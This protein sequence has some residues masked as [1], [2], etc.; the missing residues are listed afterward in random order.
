MGY[1]RNYLPAIA[2]TYDFLV[3]S[4][5]VYIAKFMSRY[6]GIMFCCPSWSYY[7]HLDYSCDLSN[8]CCSLVVP[9][10]FL[11]IN[12]GSKRV[13]LGWFFFMTLYSQFQRTTL[14]IKSILEIR[15]FNS[16][17]S[18]SCS[19]HLYINMKF[20]WQMVESS[21]C[22]LS[23]KLLI[24]KDCCYTKINLPFFTQ[25]LPLN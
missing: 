11:K 1:P 19:I 7:A 4:S 22:C 2:A 21:S 15:T 10:F 9:W 5:F 13:N 23:A 16:I 24:L 17:W 6:A 12:Q 18:I 3:E 20:I 8:T 25:P 14:Y